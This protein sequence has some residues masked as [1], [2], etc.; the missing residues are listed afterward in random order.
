[1][2]R[3]GIFLILIILS[4]LISGCSLPG[5]EIGAMLTPPAMSSG[6]E[7]LSQAINVS[8]GEGYELVYP[9]AGSYRTGIIS[10]DLTGDGEKE[11]ICFYRP[12][13]KADRLCFLVM[14]SRA[15]GWT[16]MAKGESEAES[17]GRVAFGDLSGDG[18]SEIIVGWQY[19]GETDGSY[20]VY[21]LN[22]GA[23]KSQYS[24]LYTRFV[25]LQEPTAKLAVISRNSATKT[26]TATLVGNNDGRIGMINSVPMY[27]RTTDYL[28]VEPGK[29]HGGMAAVYVDGQLENGQCVTEVLAV[30]N[31]G[32]LTNE[33]LTQ[34]NDST[35]RQTAVTCRDVDRDGVL[36]I[37]VEEDL[38]TY[39][40]NGLPENLHLIHWQAFNG[41]SLT[42][43]G[44]SFVDTT[45]NITLDFPADWYGKV[46]VERSNSADR[47]FVFKTMDG[48]PLFVLR[49]FAPAEYPEEAGSEGWRKLH[50]DSDHIH[51]VYC[52][53]DNEMQIDYLKIYNLFH[54]E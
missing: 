36:E 2:Q 6:R 19:L 45:E 30:N 16:K 49:S 48:E 51:A 38:P 5:Q 18:L 53:P 1:M 43:V 11:A 31:E 39:Y 42:E 15:D 47:S 4:L 13:G 34:L 23:A 44:V 29:T 28:S 26:V 27:S 33:L 9:Q 14:Q 17:V 10:V 20:D 41:T 54:A 7:A 50:S 52:Q 32:R 35:W 37:P 46:T 21:T 25:L 12:S 24:G 40:R 8:I 22:G 3:K